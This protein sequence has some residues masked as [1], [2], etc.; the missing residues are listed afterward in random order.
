MAGFFES[1]L[2]RPEMEMRET[3]KKDTNRGDEKVF[4]V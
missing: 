3:L 2:V 1:R 4:K